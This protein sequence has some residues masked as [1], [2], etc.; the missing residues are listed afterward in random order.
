[1]GS[2]FRVINPANKNKTLETTRFRGII[3]ANNE[4]SAPNDHVG[5]SDNLESFKL[6]EMTVRNGANG[7]VE[8]ASGILTGKKTRSF[9]II[10]EGT[11]L[12][13]AS[14]RTTLTPVDGIDFIQSIINVEYDF[15]SDPQYPDGTTE[16]PATPDDPTF[17]DSPPP[18]EDDYDP[19]DP[20]VPPPGFPV[21]EIP[22]P[23]P[24]DPA[25]P[26]EPNPDP[27]VPPEPSDPGEPW[28]PPAAFINAYE[29]VWQTT[30]T[31]ESISIMIDTS[32]D[33]N[34]TINWGDGNEE[35]FVQ[36]GTGSH[37]YQAITHVF[38]AIGYQ[39]VNITGVFPTQHY[40]WEAGDTT[41]VS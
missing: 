7:R 21:P 26:W 6:R 27:F 41:Q 35:T 15:A 17:P 36:T 38:A 1:M 39:W 29:S 2:K 28:T 25:A 13:V 22:D 8:Y 14:I 34:C 12:Y 9:V 4:A 5:S 33:Y 24:F 16:L 31:N 11:N 3:I 20:W 23:P 32:L 18:P 10:G 19:A 37:D 30:G 40:D